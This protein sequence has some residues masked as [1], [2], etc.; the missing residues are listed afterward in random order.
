MPRTRYVINY[1]GSLDEC[2]DQWWL[3]FWDLEEDFQNA[4]EDV[5]FPAVE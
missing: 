5:V 3:D 4:V 2:R 1:Y